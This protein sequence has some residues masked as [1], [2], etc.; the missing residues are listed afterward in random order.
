MS[1]GRG[2]GNKYLFDSLVFGAIDGRHGHLQRKGS[3]RALSTIS[4]SPAERK[5][6][7]RKIEQISRKTIREYAPWEMLCQSNSVHINRVQL[8]GQEFCNFAEG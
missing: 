1:L 3:V 6:S 7:C 2:R 5:L 4:R 8:A